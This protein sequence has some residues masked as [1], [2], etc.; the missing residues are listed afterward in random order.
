MSHIRAVE[1]YNNLNFGP[2]LNPLVLGEDS[3][4]EFKMTIQDYVPL[5]KQDLDVSTVYPVTSDYIS[6]AK[7]N[8]TTSNS[9]DGVD[10]TGVF[11]WSFADDWEWGSFQHEY[12]LQ[13]VNRTSLEKTYRRSLFDFVDFVESRRER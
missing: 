2:F 13:Y 6:C 8:D 9:E 12:G 7:N 11:A 3:S 1:N 5:T 10:V 4:E